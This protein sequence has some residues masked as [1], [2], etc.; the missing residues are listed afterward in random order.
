[1]EFQIQFN[2]YTFIDEI[3]S[4]ILIKLYVYALKR[5][6]MK[7]I[8]FTPVVPDISPCAGNVSIV[9]LDATIDRTMMVRLSNVW[10]RRMIVL[11]CRSL[12]DVEDAWLVLHSYYVFSYPLLTLMISFVIILFY[13]F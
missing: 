1:M 8:V 3:I 5:N 9:S 4:I 2:A 12:L 7:P 6:S 11:M 13:P 10:H